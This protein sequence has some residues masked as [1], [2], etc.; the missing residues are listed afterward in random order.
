MR[1]AAVIPIIYKRAQ[2][3]ALVICY[4]QPRKFTSDEK[5]L[6]DYMGNS[7]AQTL[8]INRLYS[9][10]K[11]FKY[12]LDN[13]LD[14][15][16]I[17]EPGT[18]KVSYVNKGGLVQLATDRKSLVG[19]PVFEIL[20]PSSRTDFLDKVRHMVKAKADSAVFEILLRTRKG[21]PKMPA[22]MLLQYVKSVGQQPHFLAIVRD[23][24]E[25]KISE[26]K[27]KHAAFHD[28][29]T[30]LPNRMLFTTHLTNLLSESE[31]DKKKFAV[32]F[33]DLDRFKFINDILGHIV[34]DELLRQAA[35]RLKNSIKKHDTVSRLGGDEFV[36]LLKNLRDAKD[37]ELIAQRIHRAF[38]QPFKLGG[39]EIYA[40]ISIGMSIYPDDGRDATRLLKNA[41]NALYRVKQQ[42]GNGYQ[43][44]HQ[45]IVIPQ[46]HRLELEKELRTAIAHNE[47]R[48]F[49]QPV[50][51]LKTGDL[52][53]AEALVRWQHPA[54]GLILPGDFI[55]QA[56][57]SGLIVPLGEW[58]L[59]EV[60]RT[61]AK[62]KKKKMS[63]PISVNISPR[64]LLQQSMLS[65]VKNVLKS[66]RL[67][68]GG[69][70]LELT[71]TFLIKNMD[72]SVEILQQFRDL[73]I[74]I[75]IDDFGTGYASLHY[76]KRL[77]ID[78]IKIDQSFVQGAIN[79]E[80]DAGIIKAM[81]SMA[82]HLKLDV[83][84]EGVENRAQHDFLRNTKC[85]RVQGNFYGLPM[86]ESQFLKI[87]THPHK[88]FIS[89]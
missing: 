19:K 43:H 8:T 79:S 52:A 66:N 67:P 84:A 40:T 31:K 53:S 10:L 77:P 5:I 30:G 83:I 74:R 42:G 81:I 65:T 12:T 46:L 78:F 51:D 86:P 22:E 88:N 72:V 68:P 41:D 32:L 13:T 69:I 26:E 56:E 58:I 50:Y 89:F 62:W 59:H 64:Q 47:L 36:V 39:Q 20:H 73:G 61:A 28:A 34:G 7:M 55:N 49:Y 15:I 3:G 71:E 76:L 24:S 11:D 6:C 27:I 80:Q 87:L 33:L 2:Y 21:L 4:N 70:E 37:V 75:L 14:S 35:V 9:N 17:F 44:Y 16:F 38:Q 82:H 60:C 29:L 85:D 23:I 1:G 54:M 57:D 63:V 18:W 45:G 25:R 48:V